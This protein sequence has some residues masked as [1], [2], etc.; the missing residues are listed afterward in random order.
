MI[1]V[2]KKYHYFALDRWTSICALIHSKWLN[3]AWIS[4]KLFIPFPCPRSR[5]HHMATAGWW[6]GTF[7]K[8]LFS[9]NRIINGNHNKTITQGLEGTPH[10][11]W[12]LLFVGN[13]RC[14]CHDWLNGWSWCRAV[15]CPLFINYNVIFG[16]LFSTNSIKASDS[17]MMKMFRTRSTR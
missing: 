3:R 14:Y 13:T 10:A 16:S 11:K 17:V 2:I 4:P 6:I 9:H 8:S 7:R 1:F 5:P 12:S 15:Q